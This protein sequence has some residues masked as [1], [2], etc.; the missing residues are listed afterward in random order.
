MKGISEN[1]TNININLLYNQYCYAIMHNSFKKYRKILDKIPRKYLKIVL[2]E[3]V[4]LKVS[5]VVL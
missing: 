1:Q 5:T 4:F 2:Q 3:N